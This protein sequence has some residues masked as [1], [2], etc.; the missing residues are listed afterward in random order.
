MVH[1]QQK[2]NDGKYYNMQ[3]YELVNIYDHNLNEIPVETFMNKYD[4]PKF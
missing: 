3:A 2:N 1:V 4:F